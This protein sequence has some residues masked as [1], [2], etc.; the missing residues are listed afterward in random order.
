LRHGM[1]WGQLGERPRR[2]TFPCA[3]RPFRMRSKGVGLAA[4]RPPR[5]PVSAARRNSPEGEFMPA[6][7]AKNHRHHGK[8]NIW[9]SIR[10]QELLSCSRLAPCEVCPRDRQKT[11]PK[12][13]R[14]PLPLLFG[15]ES[16]HRIPAG[17]RFWTTGPAVG[18][19][20]ARTSGDD[21]RRGKITG[22]G[23]RCV[24]AFRPGTIVL[25]R[26]SWINGAGARRCT[27][28]R[29]CLRCP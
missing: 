24:L 25:A 27:N 1:L 9:P 16:R 28:P 26:R 22:G 6:A 4:R 19:S 15:H 3:V 8:T 13:D 11:A 5:H 12:A 7:A 18:P 20:S 23:G 29:N 10:G 14:P 21:F 2:P 17:G